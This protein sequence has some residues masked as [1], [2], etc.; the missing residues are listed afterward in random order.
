M[1]TGIPECGSPPRFTIPDDE[2]PEWDQDDEP[3]EEELGEEEP[4]DAEWMMSEAEWHCDETP[5]GIA[6]DDNPVPGVDY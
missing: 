6:Y 1:Y 3:S 5:L 4:D 2:Y